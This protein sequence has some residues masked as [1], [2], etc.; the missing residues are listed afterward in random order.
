VLKLRDRWVLFEREKLLPRAY[1]RAE[2]VTRSSAMM[3]GLTILAVLTFIGVGEVRK[4]H[5]TGRE[6]P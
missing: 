4:T 3:I 6:Q 5:A 1:N 2:Q